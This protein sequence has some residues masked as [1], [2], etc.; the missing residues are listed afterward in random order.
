LSC[1]ANIRWFEWPKVVWMALQVLRQR[2]LARRN[3]KVLHGLPSAYS[4]HPIFD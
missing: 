2:R 4:G 3:D 1:L